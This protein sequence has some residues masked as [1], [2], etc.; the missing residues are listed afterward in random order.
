KK[1]ATPELADDEFVT[2]APKVGWS[3]DQTERGIKPVTM[4]QAR[5]ETSTGAEDIHKTESGTRDHKVLCRILLCISHVQ[6]VPDVLHVERCEPFRDIL[7]VESVLIILIIGSVLTDFNRVK[8]RVVNRD[9]PL[10]DIGN[11]K[12]SIV[13]NLGNCRAGKH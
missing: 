2:E 4:L 12:K 1:F 13:T 6:V 9:L 7:I 5:Q 8:V 3:Q 11:V 10:S